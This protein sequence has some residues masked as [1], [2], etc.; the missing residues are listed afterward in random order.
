MY[1]ASI[2]GETNDGI[3]I[4]RKLATLQTERE[5]I[6]LCEQLNELLRDKLLCIYKELLSWR[7][8]ISYIEGDGTE[9]TVYIMDSDK[10]EVEAV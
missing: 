10:D 9:T 1:T 3:S 2:L 5:A 4:D 6:E 8:D 7:F